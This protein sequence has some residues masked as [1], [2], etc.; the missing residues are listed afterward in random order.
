MCLLSFA[1]V[2][3]LSLPVN[4]AEAP[5]PEIIEVIV[6]DCQYNKEHRTSYLHASNSQYPEIIFWRQSRENMCRKIEK[7]H[8]YKIEISSWDTDEKILPDMPMARYR[9]VYRQ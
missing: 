6:Y 7:G 8:R 9:R 2:L 1:F 5:D 3:L 4:A